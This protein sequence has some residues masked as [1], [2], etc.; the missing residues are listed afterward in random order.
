[1]I[2][3]YL[4]ICYAVCCFGVISTGA[5][6][7]EGTV[8]KIYQ[9]ADDRVPQMDGD[10]VDWDQVPTEYFFD[11]RHHTEVKEGKGVEH[12]TADLHIK[13]VAVGWNERLNR[14]YFMAEVS[15]N[16]HLFEKTAD[17]IDSLDS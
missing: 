11:F 13:R 12:N 14:L 6:A 3:R 7:S 9:F 4:C 5:H 17:H 2:G 16:I 8:Y 1:M 15:D 10:P